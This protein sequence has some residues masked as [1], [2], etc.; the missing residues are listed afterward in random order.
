MIA[1]LFRRKDIK[2]LDDQALLG[3]I[4]SS[5]REVSGELFR[6]YSLLVLGL[7]LKYLKNRENAEDVTMRL[8]EQLP[9][10]IA[11]SEIKHFRNW[12]HSVARNECL[13]ELRKKGPIS[14]DIETALRQAEDSTVADH[15]A[16]LLNELKA[17]ELE[18]A[19]EELADDQQK[20][21][22]LFY[23]EGKS[24]DEIGTI[25]G[26]ENKKVKSYIQNGKRNLKLIL[27]EKSEFKK[28]I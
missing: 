11:R 6:R 7:C 26:F 18:K 27:E 16:K 4:V 8:F 3:L 24:Y 20:C 22:R 2:L 19:I 17:R 14:A 10:K 23:L 1:S 21:I 28:D 15:E 12:L 25:T 13:M 9:A 5:S